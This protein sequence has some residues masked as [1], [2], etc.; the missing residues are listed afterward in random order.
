MGIVFRLLLFATLAAVLASPQLW[1]ETIFTD[2]F[3]AGASGLWGNQAGNWVASEGVY[4]AQNPTNKPTTMSLLPFALN[5]FSVEVDVNGASDGG[6]WLR[7]DANRNGVLLVIGGND[8]RGTGLYWHIVTG[9]G[10]GWSLPL[11]LSPS[12]FSQGA[13]LHVRVEVEGDTYQAF[14]GESTT[15]AT[16]LTTNLFSMGQVGLYDF[17]GQ[18]YGHS[19]FDNFALSVPDKEPVPEPTSMLLLLAGIVPLLWQRKR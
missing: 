19:S 10:S 4:Y 11:N 2:D 14:L 18:V 5:D 12:L 1:G 13:N 6:L 7:S 15:P 16:S 9:N 17:T 8:H 3:S